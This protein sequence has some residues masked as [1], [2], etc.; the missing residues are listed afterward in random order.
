MSELVA[1]TNYKPGTEWRS[2]LT[3]KVILKV[4]RVTDG[5][6]DTCFSKHV[7]GRF[8]ASK[9]DFVRDTKGAIP[10]M[11]TD[12]YL[13]GNP[14]EQAL[15]ALKKHRLLPGRE[16]LTCDKKDKFVFFVEDPEVRISTI[17]KKNHEK[18]IS[19]HG[20]CS[21]AKFLEKVIAVEERI[22]KE[23]EEADIAKRARE[24]EVAAMTAAAIVDKMDKSKGRGKGK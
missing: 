14:K 16:G 1:G 22:A 21:H 2:P 7:Y 3:G 10:I 15:N 4:M 18:Y 11:V 6:P 19:G 12:H 24:Q 9:G 13:E 8:D 20:K 5:T 23:T 17:K